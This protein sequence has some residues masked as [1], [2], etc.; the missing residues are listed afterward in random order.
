M[1][2]RVGTYPRIALEEEAFDPVK[3]LALGT[4]Q[5]GPLATGNLTCGLNA[6]HILWESYGHSPMPQIDLGAYDAVVIALTLRHIM[7]DAAVRLL[8]EAQWGNCILWPRLI[9][10]GRLQEY[11]ELCSQSIRTR[12]EQVLSTYRGKPVFFPAFLE[13]SH[14]FLGVLL[15]RFS[16]S[17]PRRFVERLNKVISDVCDAAPSAYFL[18]TNEIVAL[19]GAINIHDGYINHVAHASFLGVVSIADERIQASTCP[20]K[21]YDSE[22]A[23]T[24]YADLISRRISDSLRIIRQPLETKAIIVD[25]DDTL[26]RGIAVEDDKGAAEF[27]EGWPVGI[28]EALLI[29]KARGGMLAICSKND[30]AQVTERFNY[31]YHGRL[32]L[33]DFASVRINF[34]RKS[35]NVAQILEEL[36]ILPANALFI[37]DNPREIEEVRARFPDMRFLSAEHYDWRRRILMDTQTQVVQINAEAALRTESIRSSV[38]GRIAA[39]SMSREE[40]L[41]SLEMVEE[42]FVIDRQ[43]DTRYPRAFELLNKTNQFNTT[44]RRWDQAEMTAFLAQEGK[45]VCASVKDRTADHGMV[46]V[47][48][49]RP[50]LIEQAVLSC[51]AFGNGVEQALGHVACGL[52]LEGEAEVVA[53]II[54]T[55]RNRTC[56]SYFTELGFT[57]RGEGNFVTAKAPPVP[58]HI[59]LIT[60]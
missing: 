43:D 22:A 5:I 57:D 17:N 1:V 53:R 48:L 45:L 18:D 49:V 4:C 55:G 32:R 21:M 33:S 60:R 52:A 12:M 59:R 42:V 40:W 30:E 50:G 9:S 23:L 46:A 24:R 6:D 20:T 39:A 8:P 11:F 51:R 27:A 26:W 35:E 56:H 34:E 37:D 28:A 14:N 47:A 3:L 15:P 44:G 10:N 19:I 36:N 25:L 13:P 41:A 31:I 58:D 16:L 7:T 54:D 38:A 29:Y 2:S